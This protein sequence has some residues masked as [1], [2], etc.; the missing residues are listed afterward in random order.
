MEWKKDRLREEGRKMERG[1]ETKVG[2][3]D[4]IDRLSSYSTEEENL[5]EFVS[6]NLPLN[7]R[8]GRIQRGSVC[9]SVGRKE[10]LITYIER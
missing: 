3:L 2:K 1:L 9:T 7:Q 8:A 5:E 10:D 4:K 6:F